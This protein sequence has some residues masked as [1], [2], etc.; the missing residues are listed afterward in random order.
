MKKSTFN[1]IA[2][3]TMLAGSAAILGYGFANAQQRVVVQQKAPAVPT[4][5]TDKAAA[6][7]KCL[8]AAGFEADKHFKIVTKGEEVAGHKTVDGIKPRF[9]NSI[10]AVP[11]LV[12]KIDKCIVD[13][14][15]KV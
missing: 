7:S 15:G 1:T 13:T 4:T 5:L 8:V 14:G 6:L 2:M 10:L 9:R 12:K 3:V 11:A